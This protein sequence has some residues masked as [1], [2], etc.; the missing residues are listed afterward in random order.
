M[1]IN[2]D[3]NNNNKQIC[4]APRG[5]NL[6]G[7]EPDSVLVTTVKRGLTLREERSL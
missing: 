2:D 3:N 7:A 4:I 5:R 6:R 1:Q